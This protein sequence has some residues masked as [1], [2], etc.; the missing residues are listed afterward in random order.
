MRLVTT[1]LARNR[2]ELAAQAALATTRWVEVR[3]DA[4][5][6]V[7]A[8][9]VAALRKAVKQRAIATCR[10]GSEGGVFRGSEGAREAVLR[11]AIHGGFDAIDV[12]FAAP[13]RRALVQEAAREGVEVI[14]SRHDREP[15]PASALDEFLR[16]V[17]ARGVAKYAAGVRDGADVA[18]LVVLAALARERGVRFAVM[19]L[20]DATLRL[21]A[22]L[23]GSELVYCAPPEGAVAAPGQ[24]PARLVEA[25]HR[26][27]PRPL[28]AT[29]AH[30]LVVLL[31]DPVGH[32]LS[33]PMQNAAFA[34]NGDALTYAAVP[35]KQKALGGLRAM[36]FA[37]A[38]VTAPHKQAILR[39][40]D[41]VA[42]AARD[43]ASCNTL[44]AR[45]GKLTGHT[46][47]GPGAVAALREAGAE[48]KEA[49]AL[50]LG[51][52][53]TGR[54]VAHALADE[55]ARVLV[56]NRTA[57]KARALARLIGGEPV[58]WNRAALAGAVGRAS[59]LL[60]CTALGRKPRELPLPVAL[61]HEK[62]TVL[63]A[64]YAPKG[65][66]LLRAALARGCNVVPGEALLLHQGALAYRLWTGKDA[67]LGPMRSALLR[68][69]VA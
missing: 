16:S 15:A 43:A 19:G 42:P 13:F 14:V 2:G 24:L 12:E 7:A 68:A 20:G 5:D 44:V 53:G 37:G 51:A 10:S 36:G 26:V 1:L 3:L 57:A 41:R 67:P 59:L 46:T 40:L 6:G 23:L 49:T 31:G 17:P 4:L 39:H 27:L 48:P 29:G 54:A 9:D 34:A 25:V 69:E 61:L 56:A 62:L 52:G 22:P 32:S 30:R 65:T 38:N 66:P 60:Q 63:D 28:E 11:A 8:G 21:L 55:G 33:P 50:V 64:V 58:A 45:N 18:A 35:V 47:D